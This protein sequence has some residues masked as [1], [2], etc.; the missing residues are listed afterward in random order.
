MCVPFPAATGFILDTD[1]YDIKLTTRG[2]G[3]PCRSL[4]NSKS[5][6]TSVLNQACDQTEFERLS[7]RKIP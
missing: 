4:T 1:F 7:R 3:V 5:L 6:L 2:K